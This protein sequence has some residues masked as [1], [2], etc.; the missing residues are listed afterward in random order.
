MR[1]HTRSALVTGVQTCALPICSSSDTR[2]GRGLSRFLPF[3]VFECMRD[4]CEKAE[5]GWGRAL[6]RAA[7][8]GALE[9]AAF[10]FWVP[11]ALRTGSGRSEERRVGKE[12]VS[13][14]RAR[15]APYHYKKQQ[16]TPINS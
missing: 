6:S 3:C 8:G 14:R 11:H 10:S 7:S 5:Q 2:L 13:T 1:R 12:E 15:G 4:G 9:A 16:D